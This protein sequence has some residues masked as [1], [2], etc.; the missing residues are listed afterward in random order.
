M[1]SLAVGAANVATAAPPL[2]TLSSPAFNDNDVLPLK[3]ADGHLCANGGRGGDISP[4]LAWTSPPAGTKS[5]AVL[6]IDPDGR[7]GIGS[8][9]WVAY[10][11]PAGRTGLKE[12]EGGT[13]TADSTLGKNSRGTMGY[14][15]RCGP[16]VDAPH[17]YVINVIA[18]DLEPATGAKGQVRSGKFPVLESNFPVSS[19]EIPCS[20]TQGMMAERPRAAAHLSHCPASNGAGLINFPVFSLLAGNLERRRVSG[21]LR[22]QVTNLFEAWTGNPN[23]EATCAACDARTFCPALIISSSST[24]ATASSNGRRSLAQAGHQSSNGKPAY[25]SASDAW[26]CSEACR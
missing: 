4:P 3:Y 9:H 1:H 12:G 13:P 7:R 6:M 5:L 26:A 19:P 24:P 25:C 16:P 2:F 20:S 21:G 15:G 10:G 23:D 22:R 14:T 11:I 17:H 18:L 8:V